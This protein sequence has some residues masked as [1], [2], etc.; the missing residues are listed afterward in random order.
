MILTSD[1]TITTLL[2]GIKLNVFWSAI[3]WS[4]VYLYH[5]FCIPSTLKGYLLT[6][7][8]TQA[9]HCKF[10]IWCHNTSIDAFNSLKTIFVSFMVAMIHTYFSV[11]NKVKVK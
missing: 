10:L 9:A 8:M 3:H 1:N 6:P 2:T 5:K 7:M 4:S 11:D